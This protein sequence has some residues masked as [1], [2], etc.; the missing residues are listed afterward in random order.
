MAGDGIWKVWKNVGPFV[1]AN[2]FRWRGEIFS[3]GIF[4]QIAWRKFLHVT[5]ER[6]ER[7]DNK[8]GEIDEEGRTIEGKEYVVKFM[9]R[10]FK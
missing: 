1:I 10:N 2:P 6:F 9:R 8:G 7:R 3:T 4:R 5:V